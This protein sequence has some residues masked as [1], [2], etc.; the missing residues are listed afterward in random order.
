MTFP[1]PTFVHWLD[2]PLRKNG[3]KQNHKKQYDETNRNNIVYILTFYA[4]TSC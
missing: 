2:L 1:F 4:S 3:K